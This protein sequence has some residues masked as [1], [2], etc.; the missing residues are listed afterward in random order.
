MRAATIFVTPD[1]DVLGVSQACRIDVIESH[2]EE[3][4]AIWSDQPPVILSLAEREESLRFNLRRLCFGS[5]CKARHWSHQA[6]AK[7]GSTPEKPASMY[8]VIHASLSS[9][10]VNTV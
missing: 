5:L 6:C 3:R 9:F 10:R 7:C 1:V 4:L 2:R 8:G